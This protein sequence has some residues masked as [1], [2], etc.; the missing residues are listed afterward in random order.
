MRDFAQQGYHFILIPSDY[1]CPIRSAAVGGMR[2]ADPLC[3]SQQQIGAMPS[4]IGPLPQRA[5][6]V[7]V[8]VCDILGRAPELAATDP[9][10]E[11]GD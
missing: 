3:T 6:K 11:R 2:N 1:H 7:S 5:S 8:A 9:P 10:R 4:G